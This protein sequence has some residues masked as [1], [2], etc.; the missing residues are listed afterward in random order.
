VANGVASTIENERFMSLHGTRLLHRR[1]SPLAK[2]RKSAPEAVESVIRKLKE[3]IERGHATVTF[4]IAASFGLLKDFGVDFM[5]IIAKTAVE[6]SARGTGDTTSTLVSLGGS[7]IAA[8]FSGG[9]SLAIQGVALVGSE[10]AGYA[11]EATAVAGGRAVDLTFMAISFMVSGAIYLLMW[12]KGW[13]IKHKL[14]YTWWGLGFFVDN[15]PKINA[16]P[17]T[18]I[19]IAYTWMHVKRRSQAAE[20]KLA[21]IEKL[22]QNEI[23]DLDQDISILDKEN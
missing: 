14:K 4:I 13:M 21:D 1:N 2:A 22:T 8:F 12:G 19:S 3:E 7:A 10:I 20:K 15:L 9:W 23:E 11:G 16:L 17:L 18:T 6:A 5:R